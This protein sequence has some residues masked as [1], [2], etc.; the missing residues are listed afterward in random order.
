MEKQCAIYGLKNN[1]E[2]KLKFVLDDSKDYMEQ[3]CEELENK[4]MIK[5]EDIQKLYIQE[6]RD[7]VKEEN[8][9]A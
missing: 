1:M 4:Y 3:I 8:K 9:D 5:F 2:F 7:Y 6:K